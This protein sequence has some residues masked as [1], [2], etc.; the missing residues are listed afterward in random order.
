MDPYASTDI[1]LLIAPI[2]LSFF[3]QMMQLWLVQVQS[4][5]HPLMS[6][7]SLQLCGAELVHGV[8]IPGRNPLQGTAVG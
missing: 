2:A 7:S 3:P 4:G 6:Y 1:L 8:R 5:D